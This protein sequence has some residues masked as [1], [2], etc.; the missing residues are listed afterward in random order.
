MI[1]TTPPYAAIVAVVLG[2][3]ALALSAL[4]IPS[5]SRAQRALPPAAS[6]ARD[7]SLIIFN[8]DRVG[9]KA[10]HHFYS[11]QMIIAHRGDT[12]RLRVLNQTFVSHAIQIDGYGVRTRVLRGGAEDTINVV[13]DRGGVFPYHC[14]IP[15]DPATASCSPDHD[16]MVGYLIVLDESR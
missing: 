10:T 4:A 8:A 2:A 3:A 11:P 1:R 5:P 9:G 14:Y 15:Y 6:P 12:L 16:T 13:T 7:L